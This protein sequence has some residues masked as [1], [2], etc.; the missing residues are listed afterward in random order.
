MKKHFRTA[1]YFLML[2]LVSNVV[3]WTFN[4]EA[5]ADVWFDEQRSLVVLAEHTSEYED[6]KFVSHQEKCNH[7]CHAIGH[8]MGLTSQTSSAIPECF[9]EYS[10]Q[11]MVTLIYHVPDDLFRPPRAT[12][13]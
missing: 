3:G 9:G 13:A 5:V 10:V 1:V 11:P 6:A 4:K 12:L 8:F 7:W 2:T